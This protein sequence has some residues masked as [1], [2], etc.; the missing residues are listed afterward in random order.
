MKIKALAA[1][2]LSFLFAFAPVSA[3]AFDA[4]L[5]VWERGRV[6]EVVLGGGNF[7]NQWETT[8]QGNGI[9]PLRFRE[10]GRNPAGFIVF[11]LYVPNDFPLGTYT[12]HI[13]GEKYPDKIIA[14][15]N[16]IASQKYKIIA[17]PFD[18][19]SLV[20]MFIFMTTTISVLRSRKYSEL[21]LESTQNLPRVED[22]I[23][24]TERSFLQRLIESP[25]RIRVNAIVSLRESLFRF[26]LIREGELLHRIS[27]STYGVFPILGFIGG[28]IAGV[29]TLR[30]EGIANTPLT[31]FIAIALISIVDGFSGIFA[32]LG[33]WMVEAFTGN[34]SSLR[35]LLVMFAVGFAWVAPS[36]LGGVYRE[37]VAREFPR[38]ISNVLAG[39]IGGLLFIF[40]H[41]LVNSVL[42]DPAPRRSINWISL[43][44]I[45]SSV[46]IR[47]FA[48]NVIVGKAPELDSSHRQERIAIARVSSPQTAFI[49]TA[50]LF[51]FVY[52]WTGSATKAIIVAL[53]F[54]LPY[55]LLFIRFT[56]LAFLPFKSLPRNIIGESALVAVLALIIYRQISTQPLLNDQKS[57]LFL[58][59]AAIPGI[60]HALYCAIYASLENKEII[61]K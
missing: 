2:F 7:S 22:P 26:M 50:I 53:L 34:V 8:L 51:I 3:S 19:S 40:G 28:A 38:F 29:E 31:I 54:S 5:L 17:S 25:Y 48:D 57:Y 35:D 61:Q 41:Q 36:L 18:L 46:A 4:P 43:I 33:F 9:E 60:I 55:Y 37:M 45:S 15:V 20:T 13:S 52:I 32:A 11:S 10:S 42:T 47:S 59:Y 27:P 44:V 21:S 24:S 23:D 12:V 16:M 56:E 6:Q 58:V 14:G 39:L 49:L 30:N 1:L